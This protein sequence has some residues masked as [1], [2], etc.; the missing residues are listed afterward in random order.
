MSSSS[1][2]PSN[3]VR[4][5]IFS[6][7]TVHNYKPGAVDDAV[8]QAALEAAHMAPCHKLTWPWRFSVAGEKTRAR[9]VELGLALKAKGEPVTDALR[10]KIQSKIGNPGAL[11]IVRQVRCDD[12]L[13]AKE[14][15]AAIACAL[16]N[17]MLTVSA[18]GY[19][20]KW[21]TGSLSRHPDVLQLANIDPQREE[22]VGFLWIGVPA[23]I[24]DVKRPDVA[25]VVDYLE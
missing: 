1:S 21:S 5:V 10:A 13:R 24:L 15:Y 19:G 3:A 23:E 20:S 12:A 14:D 4:D 25:S 22:V 7:R 11:L 18:A 9:I 2:S 16:Q 8:L 17:V 6:R